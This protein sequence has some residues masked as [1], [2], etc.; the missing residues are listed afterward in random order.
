MKTRIAVNGA[1]GR[2]GRLLVRLISQDPGLEL[3][4]ALEAREHPQL[5]RDAGELA[6]VGP[7]GIPVQSSEVPPTD[8]LVDFSSPLATIARSKE[9][10]RVGAAA[11]IGT[12]GMTAEQKSEIESLSAQ[13]PVIISPNMSIG[14]NLLFSLAAQAASLL[15]ENFDIEIVEAHHR[16]KK[17]APS[18]TAGRLLEAVCEAKG[19]TPE[20]VAVYGR[21]GITGER[22]CEQ[23][24]VH[25][26]RGGDIVGDHTVLF[27]G[28]GERI[29]LSHRAQS[30]EIFARGAIR[31]ARFIS[32]KPAGL[33]AMKDVL[34]L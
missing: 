16:R 11:V 30:R 21:E 12:T 22:P 28:P 8:V 10:A 13:V 17:D 31:V 5:G 3:T 27:A 20:D 4:A 23:I 15:D 1:A 19:W 29:E 9:A 34:G 24:G 26:V 33:Y 18:G 7:V 6:G 25:A 32:G 14:V 2:M